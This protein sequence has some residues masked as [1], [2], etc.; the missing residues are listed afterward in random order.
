MKGISVGAAILSV[1][2]GIYPLAIGPNC[3]AASASLLDQ[4]G[5]RDQLRDQARDQNAVRAFNGTI[6]KDGN[7]FVLR[8]DVN[9][10]LYDLDDQDSASKF[11][12]KKVKVT[13]TLDASNLTIHIQTI[14]EASA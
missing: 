3:K 10:T 7:R 11:A 4:S 9:R 8:D 13:G 6:G 1:A 12:G 5:R 2:F 14:E